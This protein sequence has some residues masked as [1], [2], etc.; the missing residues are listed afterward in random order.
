MKSYLL[1]AFSIIPVLLLLQILQRNLG[2][3]NN[4]HALQRQ[5]MRLTSGISAFYIVMNYFIAC[6]FPGNESVWI[7]GYLSALSSASAYCYF[8]LINMAHTARRI[9]ILLQNSASAHSDLAAK[10]TNYRVEEMVSH[11]LQRMLDL[12]V[13]EVRNDRYSAKPGPLLFAAICFAKWRSL[14]F[15]NEKQEE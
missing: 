2:R 15:P 3:N 9:Q 8:H 7:W 14:L 4:P 11:R 1:M 13:I 5:T 6:S 10:D 12:G